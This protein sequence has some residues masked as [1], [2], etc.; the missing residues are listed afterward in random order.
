MAW[1]I[2]CSEFI[3]QKLRSFTNL[4]EPESHVWS[5][6][7]ADVVIAVKPA[8]WIKRKCFR[9]Q[10]LLASKV[11][12]LKESFKTMTSENHK[13]PLAEEENKKEQSIFLLLIKRK[14]DKKVASCFVAH[15][16][17]MSVSSPAVSKRLQEHRRKTWVSVWFHNNSMST[18]DEILEKS[19]ES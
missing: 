14:R 12:L 5:L 18:N 4:T 9:M 2:D 19:Y 6:A 15:R 8:R 7:D 11:K 10:K 13:L 3:V 16:Q 1:G 17:L